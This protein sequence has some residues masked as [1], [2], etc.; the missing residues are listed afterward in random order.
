MASCEKKYTILLLSAPIGSGHKLAAQALEQSLAEHKEVRVVHGSIFDFF[1]GSIG[2]A[3]LRFY[4][5]I[6]SYCPWM[7][8]W[9]YKWGNRENGSLWLRDFINGTLAR[10]AHKFIKQTDPDAVIATH[11]TPVGIMSIYKKK[12]KPEMLL[13]AVVTDYTVHKWW[14]C[15]GVDVYF[16]AAEN[17]RGQFIVDRAEVLATGIPVRHQFY[18]QHNYQELRKNFGW[19]ND[20]VICLLMGGGEGLL[21]MK[22]IL[23]AFK[24]DLPAHLKIIAVTGHNERL[25]QSLEVFTEV[26]VTVY[27]FTDTVPELLLAT[28]IIVSKA[29]GLTAAETLVAGCEYI[30]YKPLPGQETGNA[31]YLERYCGAKIA[32]SPADVKELVCKSAAVSF[33][34]RESARTERS[35]LFGKPNAARRITDYILK[36]SKNK[37]K[38]DH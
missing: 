32:H 5:W 27:G 10:L 22:N 18:R 26:P 35:L 31:A 36:N 2:N 7:Y 14:L 23:Q 6:L 21:P 13:G 16:S 29:G 30:I 9:V 34:G 24:G 4:L 25:Q 15:E 8:D 38:L 37:Q 28:D 3:F 33:E 11:A 1:P 20:D 12:F 17:L 19:K